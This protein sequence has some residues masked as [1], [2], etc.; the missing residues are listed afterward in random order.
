MKLTGLTFGAVVTALVVMI[1]SR[2]R[3]CVEWAV[4]LVTTVT[5]SITGGAWLALYTGVSAMGDDPLVVAAMIG[6][7][8]AAGLPAWVLVRAMFAIP[9]RQLGRSIRAV[10]S[11]WLGGG[12]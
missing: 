12:Q 2:P 1:L 8:F 11:R 5:A 9:R 10:L 4:A 3:S 7:A 6:Q